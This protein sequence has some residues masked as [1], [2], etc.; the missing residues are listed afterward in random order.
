MNG[1]VPPCNVTS[2]T[3]RLLTFQNVSSASFI[4]T[5]STVNP[6]IS[7][8]NFGASMVQSRMDILLLYHMAERAVTS[9]YVFVIT[10]LSTC[11]KGYLPMKR[12]SSTSMSWQH[13]TPLSPS[14]MVTRSRR[15]LLIPNR[16][17][18]PP[19]VLSLIVV[20]AC[21]LLIYITIFPCL[22]HQP[23]EEDDTAKCQLYRHGNPHSQYTDQGRLN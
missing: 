18:S 19:K 20:I 9:K 4:I 23:H 14:V 6:S 10:E 5:R 7:R 3:V 11:H 2:R 17:R 16:G 13:F 21:F 15:V 22:N 12:Q 8:K 1:Y